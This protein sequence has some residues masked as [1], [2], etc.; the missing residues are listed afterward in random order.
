MPLTRMS[1]SAH[2]GATRVSSRRRG[3]LTP[4]ISNVQSSWMFAVATL[5]GTASKSTGNG[6]SSNADGAGSF[7]LSRALN[8]KRPVI[9]EP[10]DV[11]TIRLVT[12]APSVA[13]ASVPN[14]PSP[15]GCLRP[16]SAR[17]TYWPGGTFE[18]SNDPSPARR[19]PSEML[20]AE[21]DRTLDT[22]DRLPGLAG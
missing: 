7:D 3:P 10:A 15:H 16:R 8:V 9:A 4:I 18:N 20:T 17:I 1:C 12:S 6:R 13:T 21:A 14:S 2:P 5:D 22:S 11:C 19:A